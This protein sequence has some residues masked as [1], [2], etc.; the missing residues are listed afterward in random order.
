MIGAIVTFAAGAVAS[1]IGEAGS[2]AQAID[3]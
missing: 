3:A 1:R 2:Q